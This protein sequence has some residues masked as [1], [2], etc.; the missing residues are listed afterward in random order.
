[1]EIN[2]T[3]A[4]FNDVITTIKMSS[5]IVVQDTRYFLDLVVRLTDKVPS[6]TTLDDGFGID[7]EWVNKNGVSCAISIFEHEFSG[8]ILGTEI[9]DGK[10]LVKSYRYVEYTGDLDFVIDKLEEL[11]KHYFDNF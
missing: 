11:V 8:H 2:E 7:I 6:I 1:M 3:I 10:T 4:K 5:D 9:I